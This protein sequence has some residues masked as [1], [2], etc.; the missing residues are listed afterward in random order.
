[1][2][3]ATC[4]SGSSSTANGGA[5]GEIMLFG[6]R[7]VVDSMRK[8]VSMN[9]LSQYEQPHESNKNCN[10][11]TKIKA[12][13]TS[14]PATPPPMTLF[15]T[16]PEI[17]SANEEC[18]GL[19][20]STSCFC[21]P[22]SEIFSP[23]KNLNRRRRR[24]SLFDITTDT[25]QAIPTEEDQADQ[26]ENTT[27]PSETTGF[28]MMPAAFPMA[29]NPLIPP[30]L[31]EDLTKN[32]TVAQANQSNT[33]V[34]T[35]NLIRPVPSFPALQRYDLN[36][37]P[38]SDPLSLSLELSLQSDQTDSSSPASRHAPFQVISNFSNG[39]NNNII[40]VA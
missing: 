2:P 9:N 38:V 33:K 24:S 32:L 37:N 39:D 5:I 40:R 3:P 21:E 36:T 11:T 29:F 13:R 22:C 16:P 35:P 27:Q 30:V 14:T 7:V 1:M 12:M 25:V 17:A 23:A 31:V 4:A 34:A 19:R 15:P 26:Q 10:N 28:P 8:S 20:K 18:R 6:V